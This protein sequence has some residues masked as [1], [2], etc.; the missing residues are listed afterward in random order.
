MMRQLIGAIVQ[1][2]VGELLAFK[3]YCHCI[4]CQFHLSF[5]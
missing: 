4:G 3:H 1:L 5:K 2:S